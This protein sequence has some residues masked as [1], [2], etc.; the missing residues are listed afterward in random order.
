MSKVFVSDINLSNIADAIRTKNGAQTQY[1]P[2]EMA[3]AIMALDAEQHKPIQVNIQQSEHQTI[4]VKVKQKELNNT[5]I[6]ANVEL[7]ETIQLEA[8][9]TADEGYTPGTLNQSLINAEWG[10][11]VTFSASQAEEQIPVTHTVTFT[12]NVVPVSHASN[13]TNISLPFDGQTV[14]LDPYN[15]V[16]IQASDGY[17]YDISFPPYSYYTVTPNRITGVCIDDTHFTITYERSSGNRTL[18]LIDSNGNLM[19]ASYS[20]TV[21][22]ASISGTANGYL[23]LNGY[24]GDSYSVNFVVPSGYRLAKNPVTGTLSGSTVNVIFTP[25]GGGGI[26]L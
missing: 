18:Q 4:K 26:E 7:P 9:V 22:N 24:Y 3:A 13:F 17:E 10:D 16:S 11:T 20:G 2:R 14:V 12:L 8:T 1:Y 6:N 21:G 5:T 23:V 25:T 19:S 15:D